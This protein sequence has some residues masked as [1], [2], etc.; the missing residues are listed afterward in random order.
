MYEYWDHI[1]NKVLVVF[2]SNNL[3][4]IKKKKKKNFQFDFNLFLLAFLILRI[5]SKFE[6]IVL[7]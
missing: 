5:K 7:C 4:S 1:Q 6:I 2:F 3:F